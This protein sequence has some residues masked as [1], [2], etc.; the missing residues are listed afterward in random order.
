MNFQTIQPRED[1]IIYNW[2]WEV[3]LEILKSDWN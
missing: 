3:L 1:M 2:E